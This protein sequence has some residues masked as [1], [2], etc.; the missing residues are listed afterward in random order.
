MEKWE[1]IIY[2]VFQLIM[3]GRTM[4]HRIEETPI[5]KDIHLFLRLMCAV[6]LMPS[7]LLFF[8]G[9]IFRRY[10]FVSIKLGYVMPDFH[11]F[12]LDGMWCVQ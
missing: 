8:R 11:E 4:Y 9:Q 6:G 5:F 3:V 1:R 10:S 7:R 2:R 12:S